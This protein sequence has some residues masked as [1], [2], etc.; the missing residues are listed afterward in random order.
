MDGF[1]GK[2]RMYV[3][4]FTVSAGAHCHIDAEF[5]YHVKCMDC[6]T[7]YM[8]NGHIELIELEESPE[9]CVIDAISDDF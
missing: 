1:N 6:G 3:W 9:H 8:C 4:M 5:A 7:V 2:E